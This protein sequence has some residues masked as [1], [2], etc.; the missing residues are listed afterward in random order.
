MFPPCHFSIKTPYTIELT[1][2]E[3]KTERTEGLPKFPS[4]VLSVFP[5]LLDFEE[6]LQLIFVQ[7]LHYFEE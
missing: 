1:I 7:K 5:N 4:P 2:N 6:H 3:T